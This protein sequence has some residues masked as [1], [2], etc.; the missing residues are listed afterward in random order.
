LTRPFFAPRTWARA[1]AVL[2]ERELPLLVVLD[3]DGTI[4]PIARRPDLARVPASTLRWI[5]RAVRG[6]KTRIAVLSARPGTDLTRLVPVRGVLRIGQYGLD[7]AFAPPRRVRA[8]LRRR[9][10]RVARALRPLVRAVPG[11]L[12]EAK[13]MTVAVHGRGV[14]GPERTRRLRESLLSVASGEAERQG[15]EPMPGA[16]VVDFV[17]RG[18]DKGRALRALVARI[19][20]RAIFYFGDSDG[21]EPA[22]SALTKRDFPVRVGRGV[23]RAPYRVMG[24]GGVALF[25]EAVAARRAGAA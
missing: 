24:I 18:Y 1:L 22:F 17:P 14:R 7:G 20:P 21:D 2:E 3:L 23:T 16:R 25:L 13:G 11:A 8:R 5:G 19:R 6:R 4:A 10:E 15:F 9:C 12:L